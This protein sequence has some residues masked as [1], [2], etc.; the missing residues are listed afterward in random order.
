MFMQIRL[1]VLLLWALVGVQAIAQVSQEQLNINGNSWSYRDSKFDLRGTIFRQQGPGPFGAV[2]I[3]FGRSGGASSNSY[4]TAEQFSK[5]G[6]MAMTV[7]YAISAPGKGFGQEAVNKESVERMMKCLQLLRDMKHVDG[8]RIAAYGDGSG[9]YGVIRL[10]A[11]HSGLATAI[12]TAGGIT[13]ASGHV[14]PDP[15]VAKRIRVPMLILHG[16]ADATVP[17]ACSLNLKN[18]LDKQK[19]VNERYVYPGG[20]HNIQRTQAKDVLDRIKQ[21]LTKVGVLKDQ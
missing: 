13:S 17:P 9:S 11:E 14:A 3:D 8:R 18:I 15:E 21:W 12:I 19:V 2:L 16:D 4:A 7:D 5:L 20:A 10:A 1:A 6:L